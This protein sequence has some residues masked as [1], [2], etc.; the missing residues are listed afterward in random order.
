MGLM[1]NALESGDSLDSMNKEI[2]V[3]CTEDMGM[4]MLESGDST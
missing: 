3:S 1:I 4:N 2:V